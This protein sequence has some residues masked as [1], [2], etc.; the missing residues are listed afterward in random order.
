MDKEN[1]QF[2]KIIKDKLANYSLPVDDDSWDKIAERLNPALRKKTQRRWMAAWVIAASIAL[3][4]LIF[5]ISKKNVPNETA[6][7]PS[8]NEKTM[9]RDLSEKETAPPAIQQT[10]ANPP[11]FRK[12]SS[13]ERLTENNLSTEA[14][15]VIEIPVEKPV[16]T[17]DTPEEKP[18]AP[19]KHPAPP[20]AYF[21]SENETALPVVKHKKR[22]SL[23][24]SFGSGGSLLA[25]NA[26]KGSLNSNYSSD[27]FKY[28]TSSSYN[29]WDVNDT[30]VLAS[31][32]PTNNSSYSNVTHHLPLS[33]GVTLKKELNGRFAI[34]SGIVYTFL[35]TTFSRDFPKSTAD[36]QLHYVGIPLNIHTRI[37]GNRF[38]PWEVYLSTGGMVEKGLLSHWVQKTFSGDGNN[39]V[40]TVKSDENIK[41]LQWSLSISP[42]IDYLIY[43]NYSI[44]LEPKVSYY[45]NNDQPESV[46]TEHPVAIGINAGIRYSW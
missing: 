35:A 21:D 26:A 25:D 44:Y 16:N 33:L 42:G 11:V 3:L 15:P 8:G 17:Q 34:E 12:P 23:R 4:F 29:G 31:T 39:T 32:N 9:V 38:S 37:L 36:L 28:S 13:G 18:N 2:C 30:W 1:D 14:N 41:G 6:H 46:R 45:F 24:L 5:S 20:D 19:E 7:Q 43:K 40:I 10:V 27:L 22:Q